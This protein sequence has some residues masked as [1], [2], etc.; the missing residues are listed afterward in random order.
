MVQNICFMFIYISEMLIEYMFFSRIAKQKDHLPLRLLIGTVLFAFAAVLNSVFSNSITIN[1]IYFFLINLVFSLLCFSMPIMQ[2]LFYVVLLYCFSLLPEF[3]TIFIISSVFKVETNAYNSDPILLIIIACVSKMIYLIICLIL[4][5]FIESK[6]QHLK[7]PIALYAYPFVTVSSIVVIW[8][9]TLEYSFSNA[10]KILLAAVSI[11]QLGST[12]ILFITYQQNLKKENEFFLLR[13]EYDRLRAEKTYYDILEHQ[14]QQLMIYAHDAKNH[15]TAIRGLNTNPEI[16]K[17]ISK[18]V[19]SLSDYS[20]V[21]HS[22]NMMLD[23]ILNRYKTESKIKNIRFSFDVKL[24]N[25]SY[26]DNFDLVT[27]LNNLL[28]NAFESA[29]KSEQ[30]TVSIETDRRNHYEVIIIT[31]SCNSEPIVKEHRLLT[32]KKD[33]AAHGLGLK[34]VST[35]LKKYDGD[36]N[37]EYFEDKHEFIST[38]MVRRPETEEKAVG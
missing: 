14:N 2:R 31:N 33:S 25:L 36:I 9:L 7:F 24:S 3:G 17:Y 27:I 20:N 13:S 11:F 19:D 16:E 18:M 8:V 12:I 1:A 23:V 6:N 21:C 10:T 28:D 15:L 32:T 38:V 29:E 4:L 26:I 35:A 34:S 22:G 30:K 37:W 5:R